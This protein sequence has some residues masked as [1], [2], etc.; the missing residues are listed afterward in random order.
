MGE[1]NA[2]GD[3]AMGV[4]LAGAVEPAAGAVGPDGHSD[5]SACLNCGACLRGEYCH[6]CGQR[7]HVHRTISAFFHDLLHGVFHFEGKIWRTLP[8]LALHPGRLTRDYVDGKRASFVSPV[9]LFLFSIFL[10]F[11]VVSATGDMNPDL[12]MASDIA[13]QE[14]GLVKRVTKLERERAAALAARAPAVRIDSKLADTREELSAIRMLRDKGVTEAVLGQKATIKTDVSW[15]NQ[16][17]LKAKK[18][19]Q[20][21]IYKVKTNAYKWSWA[22]IPLSVPF[23]WLLFPFSRR[24][25]LY[26]HIVF[27]TYSICFMSLLVMFGTMLTFAGLSAVAGLLFLV[28]PFHMYRQLRGAYALG[29]AGAALRTIALLATANVTLTF[30]VMGMLALGALD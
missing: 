26:D 11:A 15:F 20:L 14:A 25:R 1:F 3:A 12:G 9:A 24:F 10:M 13:K 23:V 29:R 16:A 7:A 6:A 17:Y 22:L 2:V 19:P 30:F 8:M 21:L 5:E 18:N 27:V 28:P 4:A